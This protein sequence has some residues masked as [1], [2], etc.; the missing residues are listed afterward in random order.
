MP[1]ETIDIIK[2]TEVE[3]LSI[4]QNER[5]EAE[6]LLHEAERRAEE[7]IREKQHDADEAVLRMR[8][9][10]EEAAI[11]EAERTRKEGERMVEELKQRRP[12]RLPIAV[13]SIL[14]YVLGEEGA[15]SA[16]DE[17]GIYRVAPGVPE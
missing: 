12:Q 1:D 13:K 15:L 5:E 3:A 6:K 14:T 17:T 2:K 9:E 4:L 10:A 8:V 11:V 16:N 7:L